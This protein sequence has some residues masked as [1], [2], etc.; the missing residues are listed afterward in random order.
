MKKLTKIIT[1]LAFIV[2]ASCSNKGQQKATTR[3]D[4]QSEIVIP[5]HYVVGK[6]G[7][8]LTIDGVDDE[9]A[10]SKAAFTKSFIDIEGVDTPTYDTKVKML[11]DE[12]Y[13]YVFAQMEEPHIWGYLRQRDTVIFY[14]NDFEVFLDPSMTTFNYGEIEVNALNTVWDLKLDKPYRVGGNADNSWDLDELKTAV[15]IIGTL[16]DPSDID[17]M[18]TLEMAIPMS[19]LMKLKDEENKIPLEGEQWR[20]NF[21]RVNWDFDVNNGVYSRKKVDGKYLPEYNW[22]WTEQRVINMHEPEKWGYLQF[23]HQPTA[24]GIQF[25]KDEDILIKQAAF[26]LFR[27]T[28]FGKLKALM[29]KEKGYTESFAATVTDNLTVKATFVKT[30]AGFEFRITDENKKKTFV[31][32]EEGFL[33]IQQL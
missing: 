11:W 23:T 22:V 16:N 32:N 17:S 12:Q 9:M 19:P 4:I 8:P 24:D 15:H 28:R 30:N 20:I 33:S 6:T 27:L 31:I 14:N 21:S 2:F 13:L 3:I 7:E 29:D 5:A 26:A 10:W 1:F 18:W 25:K